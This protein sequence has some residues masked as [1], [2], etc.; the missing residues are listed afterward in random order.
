MFKYLNNILI[1]LSQLLNTFLLGNPDETIAARCHREAFKKKAFF[2]II[3]LI[4]NCIFFWQDDHCALMHEEEV[5][6]KQQGK[7]Y[8]V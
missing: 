7:D 8:D 6:Y 1:A 3:E 2:Q 4:L 5:L